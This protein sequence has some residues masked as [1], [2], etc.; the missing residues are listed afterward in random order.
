MKKHL[1]ALVAAVCAC[2]ALPAGAQTMKPGLWEQSSKFSSPDGR[3]QGMMAEMQK[4]LGNMSPEQ[5]QSVQKMME[6]NGVQLQTGADGAL[7]TRMC[8]TKEMIAR[9]E[10]PVQKGDCKQKATPVAGNKLKVSFVCTKPSVSGEGEMTVDSETSYHATMHTV[11]TNG[12]MQQAMDVNATGA[13][14]GADCGTLRPVGA[15]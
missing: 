14:V 7:M 10:F 6:R 5:R 9:R 2:A 15:K 4:Q 1:L 3:M 13:W 12:E 8:M 11:A